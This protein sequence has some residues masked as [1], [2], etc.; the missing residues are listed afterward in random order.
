VNQILNN[1]DFD[2]L[3]LTLG[4]AILES[5][6]KDDQKSAAAAQA[7]AASQGSNGVL[8]GPGGQLP[9]TAEPS[10]VDGSQEGK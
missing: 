3:G 4:E 6:E 1:P 7:A 8:F 10:S 2:S 9:G 5:L